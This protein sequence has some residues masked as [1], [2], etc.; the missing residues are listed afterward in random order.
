[1]DRDEPS[2]Q[3]NAPVQG[4]NIAQHQWIEQHIHPP[5]S[6]AAPDTQP[7]PLWNVPYHRNPLFIGREEILQQLQE[8]LTP[9]KIA[10]LT[11]PLAISG[12]GGIGKTQTAVEFAYRVRP[13]YQAVLWLQADSQEI[14]ALECAKLAELLKL[15]TPNEQNRIDYVEEV[16][17]WLRGHTIWLLILDNSWFAHFQGGSEESSQSLE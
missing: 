12:L 9:G 8:H 6:T 16:K 2:I 15:S 5:E 13:D 10:A 3:I 4:L 14:L 17:R 11:Q 1:M 7:V